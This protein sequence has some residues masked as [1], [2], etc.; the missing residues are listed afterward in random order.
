MLAQPVRN[1]GS[2]ADCAADQYAFPTTGQTT[3]QHA[4]TGS[5]ANLH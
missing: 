2:S 5:R 1:S 4:S 3:N